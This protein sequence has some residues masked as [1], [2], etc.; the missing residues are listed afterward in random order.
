MSDTTQERDHRM[1]LSWTFDAGD[2][3]LARALTRAEPGRVW[4][5]TL[6]GHHGAGPQRRALAHDTDGLVILARRSDTRFVMPGDP[7]W[8]ASLADLAGAEPISDRGGVPVGLWVRGPGHL[9][10]WVDRAVSIVGAR[11]CSPYGQG[12]AGELAAE[13]AEQDWT[14]VSGG[15]FGIDIAAHRGV[16]S[17]DGS[18]TVAVLAC[19][20]DIEYPRGNMLV[21]QQLAEHHLVVSEIPP[22]GRPTRIRFLARNRLIAAL[23]AG[24]VMVEAAA[25]SGARNT[26]AWAESLG[27]ICMAVPG[28]VHSALSVGPLHLIRERRAELVTGSEQVLELVSAMGEHLVEAPRAQPHRLDRL[29][30]AL[31]AVYEALP[32]RGRRT[33]GEVS[34][35][36]GEPVQS[37][38]AALGA[39]EAQGL[40]RVDD[41]GWRAVPPGSR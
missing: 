30:A 9:G 13:L 4:Q 39:L 17:V 32:A 12:C 1:A 36:V 14:V 23:G 25:R 31:M 21:L 27:R 33:P 34:L 22:G 40:A 8:P 15:A 2:P 7:E 37:C 41:D 19:G 24:T 5:D 38:L 11:A 29:P 16:L 28:S 20:P 18:R 10:E 3:V 26:M 6:A 35:A